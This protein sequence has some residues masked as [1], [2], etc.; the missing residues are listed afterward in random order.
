MLFGSSG[1][2][3]AQCLQN[4]KAIIENKA[5]NLPSGVNK[6]MTPKICPVPT[7]KPSFMERWI[8]KMK[9]LHCTE[10]WKY[11]SKML[12][13]SWPDHIVT[14]KRPH[15]TWGRNRW[16]KPDTYLRKT[17][18]FSPFPLF[19]FSLSFLAS[20]QSLSLNLPFLSSFHSAFF[21]PTFKENNIQTKIE[22]LVMM[23]KFC[24][25]KPMQVLL[26]PLT[27]LSSKNYSFTKNCFFL[28]W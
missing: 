15:L 26:F 7:K 9:D 18:M 12:W 25:H 17:K 5:Y 23:E 16:R 13:Q 6:L 10:T 27:Y 21:F 28:P 8:F 1:M 20:H 19:L 2:F 24:R 3:L 14:R 4:D 11:Y 22:S